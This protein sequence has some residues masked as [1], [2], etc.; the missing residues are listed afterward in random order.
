MRCSKTQQGTAGGRAHAAYPFILQAVPN[1]REAPFCRI[2]LS[3]ALAIAARGCCR[4]GIGLP[5]LY[6]LCIPVLPRTIDNANGERYFQ[7]FECRRQKLPQSQ[8]H[9][10]QRQNTL[11]GA[12]AKLEE[13][14]WVLAGQLLGHLRI[15]GS[16]RALSVR[17]TTGCR[18]QRR[19]RRKSPK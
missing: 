18:Q 5:Y 16:G 15:G 19:A 7:I 10:L 13:L 4:E 1:H 9:W 11:P 8:N 12:A 3:R 2:Y 14:C 17:A 6:C